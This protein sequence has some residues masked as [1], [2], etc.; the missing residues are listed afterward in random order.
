MELVEGQRLS[1][2]VPSG[3]LP[4]ALVRQ[5]GKQIAD[6]LAHAHR[7]G[8]THR[9][10]K[11][12]N[13]VVTPEGRAKV[14]DF[15][16]ARRISTESLKEV[17]QSRQS[18][19]AEG[20]VAG[21]LSCM[22]P[23]LF[24]GAA[25]DAR[26]DIWSLGVLLYEIATG[27][28]PFDGSTGFE[29][30]AAILHEPPVPLPE[31]IPQSI[32]M[33]I[34]RCL[35]KNPA[36]RY[37]KAEDVQSALQDAHA[38]VSSSGAQPARV[39]AAKPSFLSRCWQHRIAW[40]LAIVLAYGSYRMLRSDQAPVAVGASGRPAIAVMSFE[41][42]VGGQDTAWL[43]KGIP[44]MLLTG[45]AQTDGLDI[46]SAER[47]H[48]AVAQTGSGSLES[49]EKGRASQ[50]A[51]RAGAGAIVVGSIAKSGD[52]FRI[53]AQ[54]EDLE[55]GRILTAQSARGADVFALIDQLAARIRD[56][57]GLSVDRGI[58]RVADVSTS[59][60][61]A[62]RLF[63]LGTDAHVNARADDARS[64]LEQAV[65]IDPAFAEAYMQLASV[66]GLSGQFG[67]RREYLHKAV[68][69]ADR[70][71]ERRRLLLSAQM[72]R[73]GRNIQEASRTLDELIARY[74]ET[75]QAYMIALLLY[76]GELRDV[77]KLLETMSKGVAALPTSRIVRNAHGYALIEAGQYSNAI[78][79]FEKY[80]ELAPREANP[81]DSLAEGHLISGSPEKAVELYSRAVTIDPTFS[82]SRIGLSWSLAVLGRHEEALAAQPP[83]RSVEGFI[84]SRL[85]R[86]Q[87]AAKV[88]EAGRQQA[89]GDENASEQC[90]YT[91]IS[92][93]LSLEQKQYVRALREL[94][95]AGKIVAG[96]AE[97]RQL[98]H[99]VLIH[100]LSGQ[101]ELGAGRPHVARGRLDVL[102]QL[103][104]P[105]IAEEKFW[106]QTLEGEV[107]LAAGELERA[108]AAFASGEPPGRMPIKWQAGSLAILANSLLYRDGAAR[109]AK[110]RGDLR[111]AIQVY[112]RLLAYGPNSKFVAV[113]EPRY[114]L[115]LARLLEQTGDKVSALKDTSV[116]WNC[117]N[118][119]TRI[120]RSSTKRGARSRGFARHGPAEAVM[121]RLNRT[122][123]T[124]H[125]REALLI[126]ISSNL[127]LPVRLEMYHRNRERCG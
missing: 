80:V 117:G 74:P 14:L 45:L 126:S 12:A 54:V 23:E 30:S 61:E 8:V 3:G 58:R 118:A 46:V 49:L 120:C 53:D 102:R 70:L 108:S 29:L 94:S 95:T 25:A 87:Q 42:L 65:A 38:D 103:Y 39:V 115:E 71:S 127:L 4:A 119:P 55:S 11:S 63:S 73:D 98:R 104:K 13:V 16:L 66:A 34:T 99:Q 59:S 1:D 62:F 24:R 110:A 84:L 37:Q 92:A 19:T 75:E 28:R 67:R 89:E 17:S 10:L 100:L 64:A 51:R 27:E 44:S 105:G 88:L 124:G 121:V 93:L 41:N 76:G 18:A 122:L 52:D 114:V 90:V 68:A 35:E 91:L 125:F 31:S 5:Y 116:F 33:I 96:V 48:E 79:E 85:G 32:Q 21:T 7:H 97:N 86:Y 43:A 112:Q 82:A 6:A 78:R 109:V 113:F 111:G 22:A 60:L 77:D 40:V 69:H 107:A 123:R 36:A 56:A 101:S 106:Y 57:V 47:L 83:L 72:A 26:S 50:V 15:G 2:L 81:Y 20:M 9:D